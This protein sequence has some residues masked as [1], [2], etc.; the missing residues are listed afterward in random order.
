MNVK[1]TVM[2]SNKGCKTKRAY[3]AETFG[4][5]LKL[6]EHDGWRPTGE[7]TKRICKK[8]NENQE[9]EKNG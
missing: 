4:D 8:C 2:C 6:A 7:M 9:D 3:E 5:C 1:Y